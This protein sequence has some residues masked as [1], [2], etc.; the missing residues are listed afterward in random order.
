MTSRSNTGKVLEEL[1]R[2]SSGLTQSDIAANA[3]TTQSYYSQV[4]TGDR[5]PSAQ[6]IDLVADAM[7]L[8]KKDRRRLHTAAARDHGFDVD[9]SE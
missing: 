4:V 7:A 9:L 1:R 2:S 8:S 5:K 6:W 3:D